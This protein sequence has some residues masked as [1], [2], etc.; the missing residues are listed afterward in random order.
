MDRACAEE[1]WRTNPCGLDA[2]PD[3]QDIFLSLCAGFD[4]YSCS[5]APSGHWYET[6]CAL[7]PKGFSGNLYF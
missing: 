3:D 4:D 5:T 2:V 7:A 6:P 1:Q